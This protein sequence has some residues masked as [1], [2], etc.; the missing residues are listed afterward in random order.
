M[1]V[2]TVWGKYICSHS[3]P[4]LAAMLASGLGFFV[5]VVLIVWGLY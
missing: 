2:S 1:Q 4:A 3:V 5:A